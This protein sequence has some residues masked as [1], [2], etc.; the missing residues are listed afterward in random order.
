MDG[1]RGLP[2]P[3]DRLDDWQRCIDCL[4][5]DDLEV[6][7]EVRDPPQSGGLLRKRPDA[8]AIHW[9]QATAYILEF[10]RPSDSRIDWHTTNDL[11]K[12]ERYTPH[13]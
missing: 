8:V 9:G 10:T 6:E 11:H 3:M 7:A 4:I 12:R 1:L 13:S 2:A 5:D